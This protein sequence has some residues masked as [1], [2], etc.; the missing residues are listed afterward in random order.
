MRFQTICILGFAALCLM[1]AGVAVLPASKRKQAATSPT[2]LPTIQIDLAK[3]IKGTDYGF[4]G[5]PH[6]TLVEFTGHRTLTLTLPDG[7]SGTFEVS[8][9]QLFQKDHRIMMVTLF[10]PATDLDSACKLAAQYLTQ[11]NLPGQDSLDAWRKKWDTP[12]GSSK[13]QRRYMD[14]SDDWESSHNPII[15]VGTCFP[16]QVSIKNTDSS[17]FHNSSWTVE[18]SA[19]IQKSIFD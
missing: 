6:E 11:W 12:Q 8:F 7:T 5:H 15:P 3:S 16:I 10:S 1:V 2:S 9:W 19:V 4:S 18:W 14:T 13:Q 17:A